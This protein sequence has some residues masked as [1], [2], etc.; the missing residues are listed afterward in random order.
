MR[1]KA[2]IPHLLSFQCG[3]KALVTMRGRPPL[4]LR[5]FELGHVKGECP[6]RA[7]GGTNQSS[8]TWAD[9]VRQ[10]NTDAK[11]T[12]EDNP[13]SQS[14]EK[15]GA[16]GVGE[17]VASDVSVE[18]ISESQW[19]ETKR[20]PRKD[21]SKVKPTQEGR[22]KKTKSAKQPQEEKSK[23]PQVAQTQTTTVDK[24]EA[25]SETTNMEVSVASAKRKVE[26]VENFTLMPR[27]RFVSGRMPA[28][29]D[30]LDASEVLTQDGIY[31]GILEVQS[32]HTH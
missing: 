8:G 25:H 20:R 15:S 17:N 5:C 19:Q 23:V 24:G 11:F 26:E 3:S 2:S 22:T 6:G 12:Q 21:G 18:P 9:K 4:C 30:G 14:T 13:P 31:D 16:T 1:K 10:K 27:N 32:P 28:E 7:S 29:D